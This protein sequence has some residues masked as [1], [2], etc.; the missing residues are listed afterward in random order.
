MKSYL[1][2]CALLCLP[3]WSFSQPTP[4]YIL[5]DDDMSPATAAQDILTVHHEIYRFTE[6]YL[7]ETFWDE[8]KF[9]NKLLG[10]G[11]RLSKTMLLDFQVD[12]LAQTVQHEAFGHGFRFREFGFYNN[13]FRVDLLPPFG[14]GGGSATPGDLSRTRINPVEVVMMEGG[15]MEA[16]AVLSQQLKTR[17]L[18]R[19][20]I[21]FRESLLYMATFLDPT[22]YSWLTHWGAYGQF[23]NDVQNYTRRLNVSQGF[24]TEE[25]FPLSVQ[26]FARRST[27]NLLNTYFWMAAYSYF[28][29]YLWDAKT[30]QSIPMIQTGSVR[31][32]P[33]VR[34]GI[35]P[36]GTEWQLEGDLLFPNK[37]LWKI[38]FR[39]GDGI[40]GDAFGL[41]AGYIAP[42][43]G[44][45]HWQVRLAVWMQPVLDLPESPAAVEGEDMGA[46]GAV[47][48]TWYLGQHQEWGIYVEGGYKSKGYVE[49]E[50]LRPT[51]IL[52]LGL[53]FNMPSARPSH[54]PK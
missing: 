10:L 4:H 22:Y 6:R 1:S 13:V 46:M 34:F 20:Q 7:P 40:F 45:A 15:G 54:P 21:H 42:V 48:C 26:D 36:Y 27:V 23:D 47:A 37:S 38:G 30:T 5:W 33:A 14:N 24:S 3:L 51:P 8:S 52:R 41:S 9:G 44:K 43:T 12:H 50:R 29:G 11:Y 28:K 16:T 53:A 32:L 18:Q 17:W 19:G 25:T 39:V 49:G 35:A 31:W 2:V